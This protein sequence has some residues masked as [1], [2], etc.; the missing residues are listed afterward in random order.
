L[1]QAFMKGLADP[2]LLAQA[3]KFNLEIEPTRGE[4]L[5]ALAKELMTQPPEV[6]ERMKKLLGK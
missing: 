3:E 2:E 5:E 1:R 4:E 6:I